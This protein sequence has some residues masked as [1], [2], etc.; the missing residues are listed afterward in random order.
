[1]TTAALHDVVPTS[2]P[3]RT[4]LMRGIQPEWI[5]PP[6]TQVGGDIEASATPGA[7]TGR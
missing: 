5:A 3:S 4:V 2:S 1:V 7:Y 6:S